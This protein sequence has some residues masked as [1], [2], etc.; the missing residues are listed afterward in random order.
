MRGELVETLMKGCASAN[1]GGDMAQD[2]VSGTDH[3]SCYWYSRSLV[4]DTAEE[5]E[6]SF[7][8]LWLKRAPGPSP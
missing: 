1:H 4:S 2:R 6:G 8:C 7:P 5:G 3:S